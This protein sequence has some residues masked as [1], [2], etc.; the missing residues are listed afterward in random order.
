MNNRG[1]L[2]FSMFDLNIEYLLFVF[3]IFLNL[4]LFTIK[5]LH[6]KIIKFKFLENNKLY[7]KTRNHDSGTCF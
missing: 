1:Y 4:I 6:K 2:I 5:K 3:I 7:M